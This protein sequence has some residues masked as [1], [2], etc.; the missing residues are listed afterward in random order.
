DVSP[1]ARLAQAIGIFS[2]STSLS[3]GIAPAL[4]TFLQQKLPF[5]IL[6]SI[7]MIMALVTIIAVMFIRKPAPLK[8]IENSKPLWEILS[9]KHV[10]VPGI[11]WIT[12]SFTLGTITAFLPLYVLMIPGTNSAEFFTAYS[13]ALVSVR[14]GG[15]SLAD[16]YGRVKVIIP[17]MLLVCA[18]IFGLSMVQSAGTLVLFAL[19][20]GLGFGLGWPTMSALVVDHAGLS[21]RGMAIGIFSSSVDI[22]FFLGAAVMGVVSSKLG[23]SQMFAL[24]ALVP[25]AG[26]I[27]FYYSYLSGGRSGK[28]SVKNQ[29]KWASRG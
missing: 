16:H 28:V 17:S 11:T 23:F 9:N 14:L 3:M 7:P 22:G 27:F 20:Y 24:A 5:P 12:C 25:L 6:L 2:T 8:S 15:G 4:G 19:I 18:G 13:L 10:L 1:G 26:V 29:K 21:D